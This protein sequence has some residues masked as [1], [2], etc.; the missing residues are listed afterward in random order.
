M[1]DHPLGSGARYNATVFKLSVGFISVFFKNYQQ[2]K[3]IDL[4]IQI[5]RIVK[6]IY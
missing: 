6:L 1:K 3:I 5:L 2:N 4:L